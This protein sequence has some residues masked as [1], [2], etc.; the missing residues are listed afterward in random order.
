[1]KN[2][3]SGGAVA[4]VPG[5]G[6]PVYRALFELSPDGM[7]L[8]RLGGTILQANPAA[9][10][11]LGRTEAELRGLGPDDLLVDDEASRAL[12]AE[13]RCSGRARG[14]LTVRADGRAVSVDWTSAVIAASGEVPL[15]CV[16]LREV[17][18]REPAGARERPHERADAPAVARDLDGRI[19]DR[20]AS[21]GTLAAGVAHEINNPLS[22]LLANLDHVAAELGPTRP[23][24]AEAVGD[25][26]DGAKR[27]AGIVRA[28]RAFSRK[29]D[30]ADRR[31]L[32][33]RSAASAAAR[34]AESGLRLKA[35]FVLELGEAPPVRAAEHE[36]AQVVLNLLVNAGQAL[37]EG[38]PEAH[39][40]V[41]R[42]GAEDGRAA[43]TVRDSGAG[44]AAEHLPR[45]FDPFFTTRPVG[46]G[47]GLG[48]AIC[49]GVVSSLG[50]EIRVE[51]AP[52]AGATFTVLLPAA[53]ED[54]PGRP[55]PPGAEPTPRAR[56][57]VTDP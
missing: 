31:P 1:V 9:C 47:T 45:L 50:G 18:A 13:R 57:L 24:L 35:R 5:A 28:L 41:L 22:Y 52:G 2:D 15:T 27:I 29:G 36:I 37:P 42:V 14:E 7:L 32:D 10:R 4:R 12:V 38:R 11:I 40:V 49:H 17:A 53:P 20:L 55:P 56:V 25:S 51:S 23:D 39:R 43:I 48:L 30:A 44:I 33:V 8:A 54:A 16:T 3:F 46:E 34:M 19:T 26:I 21:I 6:D